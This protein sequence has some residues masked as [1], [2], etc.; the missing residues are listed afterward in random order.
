MARKN[1][2]STEVELLKIDIRS[3]EGRLLDKDSEIA[4]LKKQIQTM[5]TQQSNEEYRRKESLKCL[6][7]DVVLDIINDNVTVE[8]DYN[9]NPELVINR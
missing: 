9:G 4:H 5:L 2:K 8:Y 1:D 3:L 6:L 7:E